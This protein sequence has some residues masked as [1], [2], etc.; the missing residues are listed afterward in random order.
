M[1]ENSIND[2][3]QTWRRPAVCVRGKTHCQRIFHRNEHENF[4]HLVFTL[5]SL[6]FSRSLA[7][8][9][10]VFTTHWM[11]CAKMRRKNRKIIFS[12]QFSSF[13][14]SGCFLV[15]VKLLWAPIVDSIYIKCF[16]RRKTWLLLSQLSIGGFMLHLSYHIDQWMEPRL[17]DGVPSKPNID[18][19]TVNFLILFFFTATQGEWTST[20]N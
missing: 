20:S 12:S 15:S 13:S 16:G 6:R 1:C 2:K 14:V 18:I 10:C 7:S 8:C 9:L 3:C 19:L 11:D 4:P 17:D 5:L